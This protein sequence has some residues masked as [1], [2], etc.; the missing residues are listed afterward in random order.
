[1]EEQRKHAILFAATLLCAPRMIDHMGKQDFARE[2]WVDEA[3]NA[4]ALTLGRIDKK[5]PA[6]AGR[7]R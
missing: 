5:W 1:M 2:Y 4:A 6:E 3:V 7:E